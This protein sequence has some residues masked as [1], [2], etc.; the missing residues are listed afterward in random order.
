M[1]RPRTATGSRQHIESRKD[2]EVLTKLVSKQLKFLTRSA[3]A[4]TMLLLLAPVQTVAPS[5][6]TV[7]QSIGRTQTLILDIDGGRDLTP[8]IWNP[9]LPSRRLDVGYHQSILEALFLL[10][11]ENSPIQ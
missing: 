10:N 11:H 1:A 5:P 4:A 8:D 6:T 2:E 3:L 7:A 9:Y